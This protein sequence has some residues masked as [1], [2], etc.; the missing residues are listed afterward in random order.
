MGGVLQLRGCYFIQL[1]VQLP[2][3]RTQ[4]VLERSKRFGVAVSTLRGWFGRWRNGS[5]DKKNAGSKFSP[6][7]P[8][9]GIANPKGQRVILSKASH[10]TC[11]FVF[12][13]GGGGNLAPPQWVVRF[14]LVLVGSPQNEYQLK[15]A[16]SAHLLSVVQWHTVSLFFGGCTKM[17][18][19]QKGFPLFSRVTEQLTDSL[20]GQHQRTT[21]PRHGESCGGILTSDGRWVRATEATQSLKSSFFDFCLLLCSVLLRCMTSAFLVFV[22]L[23]LVRAR[24]VKL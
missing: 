15:T 1:E 3:F 5:L 24:V 23:I 21:A 20:A 6:G 11:F 17:V 13:W 12:L 7:F 16:Q 8:C 14:L 2:S 10:K 4:K 22:L 18:F 9:Q 19:T